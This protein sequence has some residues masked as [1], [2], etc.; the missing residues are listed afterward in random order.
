[1]VQRILIHWSSRCIVITSL[2]SYEI[3]NDFL[4]YLIFP[5]D[6]KDLFTIGNIDIGFYHLTIIIKMM[7]KIYISII[8]KSWF[9]CKLRDH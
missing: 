3:S 8:I 1:M 5:G 4:I 9:T 7:C 2:T 6:K